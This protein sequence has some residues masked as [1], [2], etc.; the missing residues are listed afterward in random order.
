MGLEPDFEI[1]SGRK[2]DPEEMPY[3]VG[4]KPFH[5]TFS[6][7]VEFSSYYATTAFTEHV[8]NK[9]PYRLFDS[10]FLRPVS[11]NFCEDWTV[12]QFSFFS[13]IFLEIKL[14]FTTTI[15]QRCKMY[16][17]IGQWFTSRCESASH[18]LVLRF[19]ETRISQV[20]FKKALLYFRFSIISMLNALLLYVVI[21]LEKNT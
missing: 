6:L 9:F 15:M 10:P 17:K 2:G 1:P 16:Y 18:H 7:P 13:A 19:G 21:I 12:L 11:L 8:A 5:R 3:G 14:C 4:D 20:D